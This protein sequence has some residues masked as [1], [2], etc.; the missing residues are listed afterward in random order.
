MIKGIVKL[1]AKLNTGFLGELDILQN[2]EIPVM[3]SGPAHQIRARIA[4]SPYGL[5]L[6]C[7]GV[8]PFIDPLRRVLT[9]IADA[10]GSLGSSTDIRPITRPKQIP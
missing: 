9:R 10:I 1:R 2:I 8:K 6:E 5:K 3:N 7:L 4:K